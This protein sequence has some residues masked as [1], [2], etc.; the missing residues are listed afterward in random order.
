MRISPSVPR[1]FKDTLII[2]MVIIMRT[3][4]TADATYYRNV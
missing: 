4:E 3:L 1:I 2:M